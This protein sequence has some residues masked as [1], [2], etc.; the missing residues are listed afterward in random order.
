MKAERR[1]SDKQQRRLAEEHGQ[2][3]EPPAEEVEL[4]IHS[5]VNKDPRELG[6]SLF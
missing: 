3:E 2:H 1:L 5:H 4:L 6:R